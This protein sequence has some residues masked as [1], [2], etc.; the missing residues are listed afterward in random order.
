M[1]GHERSEEE[2][3]TIYEGASISELAL[4]FGKDKRRVAELIREVEPSG[5]RAGYP[6]FP[7]GEAAKYLVDPIVDIEAW[8]KKLRPNDL[9]PFL[10]K[11]FWAAQRQRQQYELTQGS[12]WSTEDVQLALGEAFKSLK[13]S[14]RLWADNIE[15]QTS[16]TEDQRRIITKMSDAMLLDLHRALVEDTQHAPSRQVETEVPNGL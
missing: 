7:I 9:P 13:S 5:M 15:R 2:K 11:E 10:Q 6:V 8:I 16:L 1:A 4:L 14:I 12:L 3:S